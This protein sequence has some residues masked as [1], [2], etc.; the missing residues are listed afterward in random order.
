[1]PF[2]VVFIALLCQF[3]P[4]TDMITSIDVV[5]RNE[6]TCILTSSYDQTAQVWDSDGVRI[7]IF[8]QVGVFFV[9]FKFRLHIFCENQIFKM[10]AAN[11]ETR[12]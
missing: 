7:G 3:K 9:S 11:I 5:I 8:G 10:I 1:M 4:H 6:R 12:S 2:F